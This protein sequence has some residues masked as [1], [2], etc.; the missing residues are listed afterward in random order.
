MLKLSKSDRN[1][2]DFIRG[3]IG[4][5]YWTEDFGEE[6]GNRKLSTE[7]SIKCFIECKEFV[8]R[9]VGYAIKNS[10]M[11]VKYGLIPKGKFEQAG[12]DFY[13]NRNGHGTGFWDKPEIYGEEICQVLD[14]LS[15]DFGEVYVYISDDNE[16][17]ILS[18][19]SYGTEEN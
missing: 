18:G 11:E 1:L 14:K 15:K 8:N 2:R 7:S 10:S 12:H 5:L 13:L 9:A 16:I 17:E 3:Y 4:C 19:D 6:K